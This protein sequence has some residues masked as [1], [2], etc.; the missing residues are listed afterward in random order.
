MMEKNSI[1]ES[2]ETIFEDYEIDKLD[3]RRIYR[4]L[5]KNVKL[6]NNNYEEDDD[7]E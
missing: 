4:Y 6:V 2:I 5:D 7:E 1:L 3:I